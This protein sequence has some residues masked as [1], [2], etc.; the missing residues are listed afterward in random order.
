MTPDELIQRI[1]SASSEEECARRVEEALE[2]DAFW[3][4]ERDL[5]S[6]TIAAAKMAVAATKTFVISLSLIRL[7]RDPEGYRMP[8]AKWIERQS[9]ESADYTARFIRSFADSADSADS[10]GSDAI[11]FADD[12][13]RHDLLNARFL[14]AVEHAKRAGSANYPA[15]P[16]SMIDGVDGTDDAGNDIFVERRFDGEPVGVSYDDH[17][18]V[19]Y[20]KRIAE[21]CRRSV[22]NGDVI[23]SYDRHGMRVTG[24]TIMGAS[25]PEVWSNEPEYNA[26]PEDMRAA[27]EAWRSTR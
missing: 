1:V 20:V 6:G 13:K 12:R 17:D 16:E 14:R 27:V 7:L 21:E 19:L 26:M 5:C 18:D 9:R 22:G 11:D 3:H 4:A 8:V 23:V 25:Q 24:V 15:F 2:S 10:A